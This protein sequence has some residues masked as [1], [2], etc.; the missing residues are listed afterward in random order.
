[1]LSLTVLLLNTVGTISAN[2]TVAT[3]TV[4]PP[5]ITAVTTIKVTCAHHKEMEIRMNIYPKIKELYATKRRALLSCLIRAIK[6]VWG[7]AAPLV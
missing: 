1:M 3:I 2:T 5:F 6:G 7:S 4:L